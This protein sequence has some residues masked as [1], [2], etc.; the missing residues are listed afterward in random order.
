VGQIELFGQAGRKVAL[1]IMLVA[2]AKT[3]PLDG[4]G[5]ISVG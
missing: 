4:P 5:C 2:H 1:V 3:V